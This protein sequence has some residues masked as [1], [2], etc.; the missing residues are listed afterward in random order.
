[1]KTGVT[2]KMWDFSE[3]EANFEV[4][5][6][7]VGTEESQWKDGLGERHRKRVVGKERAW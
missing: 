6:D 5:R 3:T 4:Q 7:Q 2:R 1:M